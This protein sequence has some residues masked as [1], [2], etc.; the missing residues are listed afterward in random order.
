MTTLQQT[1]SAFI[2][3]H[4]G[5]RPSEHKR[6][7]YTSALVVIP[8][9][10]AFLALPQHIKAISGQNY[11]LPDGPGSPGRGW[12]PF[13]E[14]LTYLFAP[15]QLQPLSKG[16]LRVYSVNSPVLFVFLPSPLRIQQKGK[17]M[18]EGARLIRIKFCHIALKKKGILATLSGLL[19]PLEDAT[20]L[21]QGRAHDAIPAI[22]FPFLKPKSHHFSPA[23]AKM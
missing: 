23:D 4:D 9:E 20:H 19:H 3:V 2:A 22:I 11:W 10:R 6:G 8:R 1:C 12:M 18:K 7:D 17:E 16:T 21:H 13:A 5:T 14:L 15:I